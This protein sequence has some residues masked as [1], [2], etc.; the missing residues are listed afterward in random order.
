MRKAVLRYASGYDMWRRARE[1]QA[2]AIPGST[3][4]NGG[5]GWFSKDGPDTE[6]GEPGVKEEA[7]KR[8]ATDRAARRKFAAAQRLLRMAGKSKPTPA[9]TTLMTSLTMKNV[10]VLLK[11]GGST[12][13]V[14]G[15]KKT[16][17]HTMAGR[18]RLTVKRHR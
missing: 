15:S 4:I 16:K 17:R 11:R 6:E 3:V 12:I 10:E 9:N 8:K 7:N 2:E 5:S 13:V 1:C 18:P 14:R